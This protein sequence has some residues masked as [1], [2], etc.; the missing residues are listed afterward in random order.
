MLSIVA[1]LDIQ[2]QIIPDNLAYLLL[3]SKEKIHVV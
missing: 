2:V 3:A 1:V